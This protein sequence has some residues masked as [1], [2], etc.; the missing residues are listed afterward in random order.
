[1]ISEAARPAVHAGRDGAARR[2]L[3]PA[4]RSLRRGPKD[5]PRRRRLRVPALCD[6]QA[7]RRP[8]HRRAHSAAGR[9]LA[10]GRGR[11]HDLIC[12]I[13]V[14]GGRLMAGMASAPAPSCLSVWRR[15][16]TKSGLV[17]R[18]RSSRESLMSLWIGSLLWRKLRIRANFRTA[19]MLLLGAA[20]L[21]V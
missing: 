13:V 16:V 10:A 1:A 8:Q 5:D 2:G 6:V 18:T 21:V 3:Q 20:T 17:F 11:R 7:Q 4:L 9:S 12:R 14:S 15:S 19:A